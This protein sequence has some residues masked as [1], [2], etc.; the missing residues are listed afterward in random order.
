[1]MVTLIKF[2]L[3]ILCQITGLFLLAIEVVSDVIAAF[4][5]TYLLTDTLYVSLLRSGTDLY[6]TNIEA[7]LKEE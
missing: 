5:I 4:M 2:F 6:K 3:W 7:R 1:M